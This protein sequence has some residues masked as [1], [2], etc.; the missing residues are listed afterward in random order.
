M[1]GWW[2]TYQ[3]PLMSTKD[4]KRHLVRFVGSISYEDPQLVRDQGVHKIVLFQLA[5]FSGFS[6]GFQ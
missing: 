1:D 4:S 5:E 2:A 6:R 3:L